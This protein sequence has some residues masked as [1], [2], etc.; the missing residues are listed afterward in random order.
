MQYN[1][2]YTTLIMIIIQCFFYIKTLTKLGYLNI[3]KTIYIYLYFE[4]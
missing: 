1:I 3:H 2:N 4:I